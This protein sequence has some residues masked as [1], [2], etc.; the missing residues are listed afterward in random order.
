M[1][2]PELPANSGL[3]TRGHASLTRNTRLLDGGRFATA[4]AE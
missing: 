2:S 4:M 3:Q 1:Q